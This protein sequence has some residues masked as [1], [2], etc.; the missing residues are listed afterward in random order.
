MAASRL[1]PLPKKE[2]AVLRARWTPALVPH[3]SNPRHKDDW[4]DKTIVNRHWESSPFGTTIDGRRDYRGFPYPIPQY[5]NLQSIDLSHAQPS[6]GPTFLVNAILVDCDFT[7]VAMGSVSESC[8]AC[9]FD[10]CSFNQVE[11][12]GAFDGCSFVQSKLLKC[13]SNATFTDCDFRNAN[14]SGTDFSR[15]RFVRC[16][17]DGASFKGCDLHKAVFVGSRPS[18][19]QLAACYGNAGIRFEDESGQQ[20][21]VVTPPAAEDPLMT[22]WDRLAQRLSDRS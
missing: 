18:E 14:L 15:A 7:G 17:F 22:A 20:V 6:D 19:E 3:L 4:R 2:I 13:A 9:R 16:S 5:Q 8:V 21:D 1:T 11:L 10:L 12:C